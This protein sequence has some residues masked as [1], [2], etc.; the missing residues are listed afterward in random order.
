M[1]CEISHV[2]CSWAEVHAALE[3]PHSNPVWCLKQSLFLH[4]PA[5]TE[6]EGHKGTHGSPLCLLLAQP[7]S[8]P[9]HNTAPLAELIW[10]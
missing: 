4:L 10:V 8:E 6:I 5:L 3:L 1:T 7:R 2:V 9:A